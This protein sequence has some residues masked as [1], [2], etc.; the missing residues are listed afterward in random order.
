MQDC[1][2]NHSVLTRFLQ[3]NGV[4]SYRF[5][6]QVCFQPVGN[7]QKKPDNHES[8][9]EFDVEKREAYWEARRREFERAGREKLDAANEEWWERYNA[10]MVSA[11]W[12]MLRAR[13]LSRA[14]GI[15]E[16]CGVRKAT[17]AHHL[18]YARLGREMLFDLVA[19][20]SQCHEAI[21]AKE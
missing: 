7:N 8:L 3:S 12:S 13:V 16:G 20:C 19:V 9:P 1:T 10:H 5:Q 4:Y 2:H 18:T 6:C 14:G 17:Q 15:C 21:H 11:A